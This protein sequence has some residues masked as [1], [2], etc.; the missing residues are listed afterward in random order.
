ME[1]AWSKCEFAPLETINLQFCTPPPSLELPDKY[2][3][4]RR[5][6]GPGLGV[7][8]QAELGLGDQGFQGS[9]SIILAHSSEGFL[10]THRLHCS[11][12]LISAAALQP[13]PY[14]KCTNHRPFIAPTKNIN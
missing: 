2:N 13:P 9:E 12:S 8:G 10:T 4:C 1:T 11:T 3:W 6:L 7:Q 14:K 5:G